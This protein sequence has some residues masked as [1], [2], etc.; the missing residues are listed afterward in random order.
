MFQSA[1]NFAHL[2]RRYEINGVSALVRRGGKW[3]DAGEKL[4]AY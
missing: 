2:G 3:E 1:A 4:V